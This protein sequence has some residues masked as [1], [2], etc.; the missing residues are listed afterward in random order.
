MNTR[1]GSGTAHCCRSTVLETVSSVVVT[2]YSTGGVAGTS[3]GSFETLKFKSETGMPGYDSVARRVYI[4]L[5]TTNEVA[6]IDP[7]TDS[8]VG[9]SQPHLNMEPFLALTFCIALQG[10]FPSPN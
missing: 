10:I 7:S 8:I 9:G 6:E 1:D 3:D 5:R 2:A 4:N